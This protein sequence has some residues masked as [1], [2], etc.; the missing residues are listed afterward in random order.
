MPLKSGI[1]DD[2][3][4]KKS[5]TTRMDNLNGVRI[6][7]YKSRS[8][9]QEI[10]FEILLRLPAQ[11]IHDVMRR[12]YDE[13]KF[14]ISTKAFIYNHLWNSTP[15]IIIMHKHM[16]FNGIYVE[17]RRGRLEICKF[18]LMDFYLRG[19]SVNGLVLAAPKRKEGDKN[20]LFII[21]PLTKQQEA[22]LWD[23]NFESAITLALDEASMKYK[24]V[25]SLCPKPPHCVSVL[26]I[27]VDNDWRYLDMKHVSERGQ[28]ALLDYP[29]A[30]RGYVHWMGNYSVLTLNVETET[31]YEFPSIK[32]F[33]EFSPYAYLAMGR[34]LSCCY[35][36]EQPESSGEYLMEVIEM[37]P[38]TG[39]WTKLL[40]FDLKPLSERF[41][42]SKS[43][44][45]FGVL[46]GGEVFLF[47]YKKLCVAY[48]VQTREIQLFELEKRAGNY[49][50]VAHVNSMIWYR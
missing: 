1:A 17:M 40:S 43:F 42:S 46:G 26:T 10:V 24:A 45:P 31:I 15:G 2:G 4:E 6:Y 30:T 16:R 5:K 22:V 32:E 35:L 8:L 29:F 39:E 36:P 19:S 18:D 13:W 33:K 20:A 48:N 25:R 11:V 21:N 28:Q 23:I 47:G 34:N 50:S 9:P 14:V 27:G 12:V 49:Y 38:E 44:E 7:P 3:S 41:K 37:N